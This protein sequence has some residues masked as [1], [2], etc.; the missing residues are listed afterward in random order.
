MNNTNMSN[1]TFIYTILKELSISEIDFIN[2]FTDLK[3]CK[4][5]FSTKYPILLDITDISKFDLKPYTVF[6]GKNRYYE[7][8]DE[9]MFIFENRRYLVTNHWFSTERNR[10][11]EW[12]KKQYYLNKNIKL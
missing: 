7:C 2:I 9:N 4:E 3:L 11:S 8:K 10:L 6:S 5:L 12:L 1:K